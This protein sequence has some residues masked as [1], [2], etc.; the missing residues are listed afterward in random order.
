MEC[1]AHLD[2]MKLDELVESELYECGVD[3]LER[4]VASSRSSSSP[5]RRTASNTFTILFPF[6]SAARTTGAPT[7]TPTPTATATAT[8]GA[9]F[10]TTGFERPF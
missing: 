10:H 3:L 2:V 4:I 9:A 5:D 7:P 6:T 1:A 8:E